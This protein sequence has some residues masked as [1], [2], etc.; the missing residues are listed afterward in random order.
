MTLWQTRQILSARGLAESNPGDHDNPF[1]YVPKGADVQA[2]M[3]GFTRD[4]LTVVYYSEKQN[5]PV[6][7]YLIGF[8]KTYLGKGQF[9]LF[10][11]DHCVQG[12]HVDRFWG[13]I[14]KGTDKAFAAWFRETGLRQAGC[15][16]FIITVFLHHPEMRG[17]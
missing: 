14:P 5:G 13:E 12:D 1:G 17:G 6:G 8:P 15:L 16:D 3:V 4:D 7:L 2:G 10:F 11:W 9:G